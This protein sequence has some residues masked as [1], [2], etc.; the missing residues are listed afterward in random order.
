MRKRR[1]AGQYYVD[2]DGNQFPVA[3]ATVDLPLVVTPQDFKEG[4]PFSP[5]WCSVALP[6]RREAGVTDVYIGSGKDCYVMKGGTAIH[7]TVPAATRN[8]VDLVDAGHPP[9]TAQ[10]IV[11]RA[12]TQGRTLKHRS[13]LNAR[14]HK[15]I[16]AGARVK[17][18]LTRRSRQQR[19]GVSHR[20]RANVH[21]VA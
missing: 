16:K 12:P 19:L 20:P 13:K 1:K 17:R 7:H 6:V 14:R 8:L 5:G 21:A 4:K 15:Q 10:P 3:E 11:L 2:P 18:R 9:E